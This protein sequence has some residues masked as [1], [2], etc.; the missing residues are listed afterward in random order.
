MPASL[1]RIT[2]PRVLACLALAA[3]G[4]AAQENFTRNIMITGYWPPTNGMV[5][6]FSTSPVQNPGGWQGGNWNNS[7]YNVHSFFP[8]FPSPPNP[9]TA[10]GQGEGDFEIDYQ[11]TMAD[12][13]RIVAEVNPVAIITFSRGF[14]GS[15]WEV[16]GRLRMRSILQ[17]GNDYEVP[18]RPSADMPI[19]DDLV[20]NTW[21]D[22]TLPT[23]AIRDAVADANV[24]DNSYIDMGGGGAFLSEFIGLLGARHQ[25]LN[26]GPD[27]EFR[28]FAAGHIHVGIDTPEGAASQATEITLNELTAYLDT[29]IP[30]PGGAV[31]LAAAGAGLLRR[32]R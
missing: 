6:Q 28:T 31:L 1:S 24:V 7:G 8:E 3:G 12:W 30:A 10:W 4:A 17:W 29:V 19:F 20:P 32:R 9:P 14:P 26:G 11:D 5:R 27:A 2:P 25:L 23:E 21:Y 13:E 15:N 18:L 16:E 22:S